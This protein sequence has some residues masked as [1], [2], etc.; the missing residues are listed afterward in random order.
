M[1]NST[2][3]R[4]VGAELFRA[5][6]RTDMNRAILHTTA[7]IPSRQNNFK[8]QTTALWICPAKACLFQT[9]MTCENLKLSLS[10]LLSLLQ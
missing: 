4:P 5:D 2:K 3:S 6:G 9:F 10:T 1:S 7:T 8:V